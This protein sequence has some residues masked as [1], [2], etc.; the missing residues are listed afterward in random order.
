MSSLTFIEKRTLESFLQMSGGYVL[1]FSSRTFGE[2]VEEI[3][4]LNIEDQRFNVKGPS[5]ANRLKAIWESES[6]QL[7][8]KLLNGLIEYAVLPEH[9]PEPERLSLVLRCQEIVARLLREVGD[10]FDPVNADVFISYRRDDASAEAQLINRLLKQRLGA[11]KVFMDVSSIPPGAQWPD[12]ITRNLEA[13][14]TVVVVIGSDWLVAGQDE[15]G[16]RRIDNES[17]WVRRELESALQNNKRVIPVLVKGAKALPEHALPASLSALFI[18]QCIEIRRDFWD[19]DVKLLETALVT[20]MPAP[21]PVGTRSSAPISAPLA[22]PTAAEIK[23]QR[24]LKQLREV[25]RWISLGAMDRFLYWLGYN[26]WIT[27]EGHFLWERLG[28]LI[29]SSR[30]DLRDPELKARL[31]AFMRAWGKCFTHYE[32]M[33]QHRNG[34]V[35]FFNVH[36]GDE[37]RYIREQNKREKF[38]R[39]QVAPTKAALDFFLDHVREHY[40]EIDLETVGQDGLDEYK[41]EEA[42]LMN[43][44]RMQEKL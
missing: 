44:I 2:F 10:V 23:R 3:T 13:A 19:H 42:Q 4:G 6:D 39:E 25:F 30:F 9:L 16:R 17:D 34:K 14:S 1:N 29:E 41:E 33:D 37:G 40:L 22:Q 8:G 5:K 15:W 35:F 31:I 24:D 21:P 20:P 28:W 26:G 38:N 12:E 27:N 18:R 11:N 43:L 36:D 32:H 7:V